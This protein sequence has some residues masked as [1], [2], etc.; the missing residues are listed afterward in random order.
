MIKMDSVPVTSEGEFWL[1][2]SFKFSVHFCK[3]HWKIIMDV[4]VQKRKTHTRMHRERE[5]EDFVN[6]FCLNLYS[7]HVTVISY[8]NFLF[9]FQKYE[10]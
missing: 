2:Q 1:K 8:S 5:R 7:Q 10:A 3:S 9:Q 4:L 6:L